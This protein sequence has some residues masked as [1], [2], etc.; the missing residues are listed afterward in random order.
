M[1]FTVEV[2]VN[3]P[4]DVVFGHIAD[5]RN[6]PIWNTRISKVE[7]TSPEP[8][9]KGSTFLSTNRGTQSLVT[10][11]EY[12]RPES[13]SYSVRGKEMDIDARVRVDSKSPDTAVVTAEYN[14]MSKGFFKVVLPLMAPM[15]RKAFSG[16][17]KN[18]KSFSEAQK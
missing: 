11:A 10:L 2:E 4:A 7:M 17:L 13:L 5:N 9:G 1:K 14:L 3:R 8:V 15:L 12:N 16:E 6:E 18:F